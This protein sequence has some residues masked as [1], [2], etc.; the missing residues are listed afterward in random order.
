MDGIKDVKLFG[1]APHAALRLDPHAPPV[2]AQQN[3]APAGDFSR[4][5]IPLGNS[6]SIFINCIKLNIGKGSIGGPQ[7]ERAAVAAVKE[8]GAFRD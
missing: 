5:R 1:I 2:A 4:Q 6:V 8:R 3:H 7:P